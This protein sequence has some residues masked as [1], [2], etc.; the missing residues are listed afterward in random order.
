[1]IELAVKNAT[2]TPRELSNLIQSTKELNSEIKSYVA[3]IRSDE[4]EILK[5]SYKIK[6][7]EN[8]ERKA[9]IDKKKVVKRY[10]K[11][12]K[13]P[14]I[15]S[16]K[17]IE[18][19]GIRNVLVTTNDLLYTHKDSSVSPYISGA[20]KILIPINNFKNTLAI[21]YKK[22]FNGFEKHHPCINNSGVCWGPTMNAEI[23]KLNNEYDLESMIYFAIDFLKRPDYGRPH[24]PAA[25]FKFAQDVTIEPVDEL[26][27]FNR[28]Y[29][30][31][32]QE[33]DGK[34]WAERT[35]EATESSEE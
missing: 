3:Q 17:I 5:M 23:E 9:E 19:D 16:I 4:N 15:K 1:M 13:S 20:Y 34:A 14:D 29:W 21:N 7:I 26:D 8:R 12:T 22:H 11:L 2:T 31:E 35:A 24:I 18:K 25:D 30:E 32:N 27:W 6:E 33:W 28:S 10:K